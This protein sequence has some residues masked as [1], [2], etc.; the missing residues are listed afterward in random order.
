MAE[1]DDNAQENCLQGNERGKRRTI[2]MFPAFLAWVL[3]A[4]NLA[5]GS[6]S[7]E[8]VRHDKLATVKAPAHEAVTPTLPT[9]ATRR[10]LPSG[11]TLDSEEV[12]YPIKGS[13]QKALSH[14]MRKYGPRIGNRTR[15]ASTVPIVELDFSVHRR[16]GVCFLSTVRVHL[17]VRTHLPDWVDRDDASG[18]LVI[19]WDK[20]LVNLRQHEQGHLKSF[21][22]LAHAIQERLEALPPQHPPCDD[23]RERAD[24]LV[25]DLV[26]ASNAYTW[27][28]DYMTDHGKT[29]GA[30]GF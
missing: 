22:L 24:A 10:A 5:C 12:L 29:Q 11:I 13:T 23:A 9:P 17:R 21:V 28:Y 6:H 15:T 19:A 4:W 25:E 7:E 20:F 3:A 30:V 27:L 16:H 8:T 14:E 26:T 18:E 2:G 1:K